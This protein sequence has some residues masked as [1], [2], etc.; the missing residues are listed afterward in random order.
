VSLSQ[1]SLRLWIFIFLLINALPLRA[2]MDPKMKMPQEDAKP[3]EMHMHMDMPMGGPAADL[4]ENVL[5]H[6][7]SGTSLE[8]NSV[9]PPMLMKMDG[10]W[11]F[12]VHGQV[13]IAD[14]QQTGPRA[15]DKFFSDNWFMP[16]AMHSSPH[17]QLTL[18]MMLSLE[19]A[20]ISGRYFPELFQQGETAFG[21]AIVD[22]QHPHN[23]F[24]EIG[25]LYDLKVSKHSLLTFYVAPV[26]D[27]SLG[28]VAY[29]HRASAAE[30]PIAPL[31]HH[32]EDSTH[33]ADEVLTTGLTWG[34]V[35][36]EA[37]GFHG[38]EPDENRWHIEV[39]GLDSW[40]TR[41]TVAPAKDWAGQYS[42]GHLHSPEGLHPEENVLR[43]TASISYH[44]TW[45]PAAKPVS[46]DALVVWGRNHT[47]ASPENSNGYLLEATAHIHQRHSVWTRIENVDRTTDLLGAQAPPEESVIGRVQAY[48][49]G[50]AHHLYSTSWATAELGAQVTL[51]NTPTPLKTQ[52]GDHPVGV[53]TVLNIHLG[54]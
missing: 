23:L 41:L 21:K 9:D 34:K 35:H 53:A 45:E 33:I 13:S 3:M 31:G 4:R 50:Y 18:R 10:S 27:P 17:G 2:Q 11:M 7:T 48:T 51:Y 38:R 47:I 20:T 22:G 6:S 12:M 36:L 24:M 29:P 42:I 37:S 28:P 32:L 40:S 1:R 25:A 15:H 8:P 44:H 39:G 43:Q 54:H 52:Y 30:N 26:G 19:P 5:R 49:G 14:Q 16:M 46:L